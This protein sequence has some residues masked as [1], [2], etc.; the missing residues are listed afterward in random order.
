MIVFSNYKFVLENL[1][2][3]SCIDCSNGIA[4]YAL[5][6]ILS[7]LDYY[8]ETVD[9]TSFQYF[10]PVIVEKLKTAQGMFNNPKGLRFVG[11]D[12]RLGNGFCNNTTPE[13]QQVYRFIAIRCFNE[14]GAALIS[15]G[16]NQT[17][18]AYFQSVA[19]N[20]TQS[21]RNSTFSSSS[22][23]PWYKDL[24]LHSATDAINAGIVNDTE[25]S[26]FLSS[27][28]ND[29]VVL[30]SHSN[31]Q[32]YFILQAQAILG[33][34]D[35]AVESARVI[36]GSEISL[37]ATT[38]WEISHPDLASILTPGPSPI[39]NEAGWCSLA[40]P[41]SSGIT[42]WLTKWLLGI[43]PLVPGYSRVLIAPHV[44]HTMY[45]VSGS[46]GTIHGIIHVNATR[47]IEG[48]SNAKLHLV[49]PI[50][51]NEAVVRLSSVL[52]KRLLGVNQTVDL[53]TI[54]VDGS[55]EARIVYPNDSPLLDETL[56]SLGRAPALELI[57]KGGMK[58]NLL[59][60]TK[61]NY[62]VL[63]WEPLGS[64]FPPPSWPGQFLG[65]DAT[66][67]GNW[68]N[69]FGLEGYILFGYDD[70]SSDAT[71]GRISL[72]SFIDRVEIFTSENSGFNDKIFTWPSNSTSRDVRALQ[73]PKN[74][75]TM[76]RRLGALA[77]SG[78]GSA[79]VDVFVN[80][81]AV[82]LKYKVSAYMCDFG[83]TPWGDGQVGENRTQEVYLLTGYPELNP[84]T[85]RQKLSDF[86]QG[87]WFSYIIEG[88]FRFRVTTI[89][90][91]Y[92]VLSA[93]VFDIVKE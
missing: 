43:R 1:N 87:V 44:A 19:A 65:T 38:F 54:V 20:A 2:R 53:S 36:W 86:S 91:D 21:V 83:P 6:F 50:G 37:G 56:T 82:N 24:F 23:N 60:S 77:P 84:L 35:M 63:E 66:T 52:I 40:H 41:W 15:S 69:N 74:P 32:Q 42:P 18:G 48:V 67:Q 30:P 26:I 8:R 25:K 76:Q 17:L 3:T 68:V 51:V 55:Y 61:D 80:P 22:V 88:S 75:P 70:N 10:V 34:L 27:F 4:T 45:G 71:I 16:V 12:D 79:L 78:S 62:S 31:F 64:P 57:L 85:P 89:R 9:I 72:P 11:H 73:D 92:A 90:G 33:A 5:Y 7:T 47:V 81:N 13:T 28:F 58:H 46:V 39:P 59:I 14:F 49:L 93:L 29:I